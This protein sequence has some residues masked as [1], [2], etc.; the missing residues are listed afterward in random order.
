MLRVSLVAAVASAVLGLAGCAHPVPAF[1]LTGSA[2]LMIPPGPKDATI[3]R[4]VV[5]IPRIPKKTIC[6]ASPHGLSIERK[7]RTGARVVVTR[8]AMDAI[9]AQELYS[10]TLGLETAGCLPINESSRLAANI[11]DALPLAVPK[12]TQLFQARND[13]TPVNSLRVVAPVMKPGAAVVA[14]PLADIQ[15]VTEGSKPGSIDVEVKLKPEVI[16]YEIDWYDFAPREGGPGY[17]LIPRSAEVHIGDRVE[18]PDATTVK[19]F[20]FGPAARW[21]ELQMMTKVSTN[22]FDFVV[23]SARTS[24]ELHNS[25][26]AFQTDATKYLQTADPHTY[27]VLPHG[28]GINAYIRVKVNGVLTDLP[29]SNTIRQA[30]QQAGGNPTAALEKLKIR[31]LHDGTLYPVQWP[32]NTNAILS[33]PL[34]GG[35]DI[36]W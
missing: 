36:Q 10:W 31:K 20:E 2:M 35:E 19:R 17:R 28:S 12:R 24:E 26:A 5:S 11:V 9:T 15:S 4:A 23:F 33:L 3:A 6:T 14:G 34:E 16:G 21:Y 7:G 27:T 13:L 18:H 1:R 29:K 32:A 25:V 8:A 22:D 30:I